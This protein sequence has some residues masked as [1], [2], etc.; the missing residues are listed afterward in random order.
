MPPN[1]EVYGI[2]GPLR[3]RVGRSYA[4]E[5]EV[6]GKRATNG[7]PCEMRG[8]RLYATERGSIWDNGAPTNEGRAVICHRTGS[9]W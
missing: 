3:M 4:T 7:R 9:V 5:R 6:Y 8:G 1:G 2:T